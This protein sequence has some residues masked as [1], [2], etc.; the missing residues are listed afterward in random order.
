MRSNVASNTTP[1]VNFRKALRD[2]GLRNYLLHPKRVVGRPD[3][4]FPR[5]RLAVFVHG[6][7]WHRCPSC[8]LALPNSNREFW[9]RKFLLNRRRDA[10][11]EREL[12]K[13]GWKVLTVWECYLRPHRRSVLNQSLKQISRRVRQ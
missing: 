2:A 9:K 8:R 10:R 3:V 1:E 7:F 4:V 11:K 5:P 13:A 6:C 12:K